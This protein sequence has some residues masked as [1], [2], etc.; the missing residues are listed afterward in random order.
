MERRNFDDALVGVALVGVTGRERGTI[1]R[2]NRALADLVARM[3]AELVGISFCELVHPD[4]RG[5]AGEEFGTLC[6]GAA[7]A[8]EGEGRLVAADGRVC[9]VRAHAGLFPGDGAARAVVMIRLTQ[10]AE[11]SA[12]SG[13]RGR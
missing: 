3:P 12:H 11:L 6:E 2:A 9:W 10:I 7:R 4:D 5:Y 8:C 13:W 1:V